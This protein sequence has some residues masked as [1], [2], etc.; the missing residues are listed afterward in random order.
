MIKICATGGV[1]SHGDEPGAQQMTLDEMKAVV[2]EAHMAD[3]RVAAHAHGA[4]GIKDAI[5]AGV[6]TIEHASYLDDAG[7]AAAIEQGHVA[8]SMDVYD[9]DYIDTEGRRMNWPEEF[10]RKNVET[11][12]IQRQAFTKAVKAGAP[13]VFGTDSA[14]YPHGFNARQFPIMVQRGMTPMQAIQAATSVAA[15]YLG[16]SDRVGALEAGRFGDLIAV[17]GDP[18][19]DIGVLQNIDVVIKGGLI[20]K[21]P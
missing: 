7:I 21:L 13:M 19:A 8:F 12:E 17:R 2:E 14:V 1:F 9:G 16:W 11:T 5:R 6:D 18:L 15:N 3:L 10:L 20:F 4:A